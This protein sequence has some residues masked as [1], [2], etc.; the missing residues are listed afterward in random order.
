VLS[1]RL[2]GIAA[3]SVLAL[4]LGGCATQEQTA[5]GV[6]ELRLAT[7]GTVN[8]SQQAFIDRMNELSEGSLDLTVT[9]NWQGGGGDPDEVAITKAVVAGDIDIA[10]VTIRSLSA[11]GITGIDA[12]EAPL[13]VQTHDQQRAVALGVPGELI[14]NALRNSDVEGLALLPGP[15][16][17]PIASGAPVIAL[18][19]WAG[20]TVPVS[21]L[22]PTE[23]ATVEALGAT[24]APD[25]PSSIADV[26]GG[27]IPMTTGAPAELVPGGVT[28]D[29]PFLTSNVALWSKMSIIIINRDVLDRLSNRQNGFL[30]GSV[31]RAQ[32]LAMTDPDVSTIISE[33]C[34]GGA[35]YGIASGADLTALAEA[36]QPV[37]AS[38]EGDPQ[39]A[40]L[41]EAIQDVVKRNAGNGG[42]GVS[43]S[44]RW[45]A[46]K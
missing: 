12:L 9:E 34:K 28:E 6:D 31:V 26:V 45:V 13:L 24:A 8:P 18:A 7:L 42:F 35:L 20:K 1:P 15:V 25:G 30:E 2:S 22:N 36:V 39:D 3:I 41:L 44:C 40:R 17:Y 16:Q 5:V 21:S 14:S 10:W 4:V 46:P 19:D 23:A 33:S 43:K 29:G 37:Y 38:L 27:A 32:D 11:I